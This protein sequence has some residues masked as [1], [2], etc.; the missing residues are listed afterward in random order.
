MKRIRVLKFLFVW[1]GIVMSSAILFVFIPN[2]TMTWIGANL[3]LPAFEITP[4]FEYM[5]RGMSSIC[6]FSGVILLYIGFHIREHLRLI[7]FMGWF[8]LISVPVVIFIHVKV[9]TPY[10]WKVCDVAAMLF[11]TAMCLLTPAELPVETNT[12]R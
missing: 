8:A 2:S 10:W 12:T 6:F 1:F 11:L 4:V 3:D 5:A 7:R 9:D